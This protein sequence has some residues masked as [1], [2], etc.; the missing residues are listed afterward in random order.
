[1]GSFSNRLLYE[2]IH[3]GDVIIGKT[4]GKRYETVIIG[5]ETPEVDWCAH[6]LKVVHISPG[7]LR[8]TEFGV[9]EGFFW[10]LNEIY[11]E[12]YFGEKK[13]TSENEVT[14][15][16]PKEKD[17]GTGNRLLRTALEQ[18]RAGNINAVGNLKEKLKF[19]KVARDIRRLL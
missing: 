3:P 9:Y 5:T 8:F 6:I 16:I 14:A 18:I 10:P 19:K 17:T 11:W 7:I 2:N 15:Y 12:K 4:K 1:M 13:G